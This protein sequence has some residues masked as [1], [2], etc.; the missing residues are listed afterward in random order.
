MSQA[1]RALDSG[2]LAW[3]TSARVRD[4]SATALANGFNGQE[5]FDLGHSRVSAHI[6]NLS[7]PAPAASGGRPAPAPA[8]HPGDVFV[9][10][11]AVVAMPTGRT[12]DCANSK[13]PGATPLEDLTESA[14]N[15]LQ[16]IS[17]S[18]TSVRHRFEDFMQSVARGPVHQQGPR[19]GGVSL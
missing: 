2:D 18:S 7:I 6:K 17:R 13:E 12:A 16:E 14:S 11:S 9:V 1:L 19:P 3:A 15:R 8:E 4:A 5:D 10:W